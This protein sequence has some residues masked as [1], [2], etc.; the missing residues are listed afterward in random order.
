MHLDGFS[1][2]ERILMRTSK[3]ILQGLLPLLGLIWAIGCSSPTGGGANVW[4]INLSVQPDPVYAD[5]GTGIVYCFLTYNNERVEGYDINFRA[6]SEEVSNA[7]IT[8]SAQSS[9]SSETGTSWTVYYNPNDYQGDSDTIYAVLYDVN[10]DTVVWNWTDVEVHHPVWEMDLSVQPDPV[11]ADTGVGIVSCFLTV[12][13]QETEGELINFRAA[14][15]GISD[16]TVTSVSLSSTES[17]TG[18]DPTVYYYP[19]NYGGAVDTIFAV[20]QNITGDTLVADTALVN[21]LHP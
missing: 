2:P 12:D 10:D 14:S 11:Y 19:N 8:G 20:F 5:T 16:A 21:I 9:A 3:G 1:S 15:E 18:T 6:Y 7:N 13:D 4:A 17:A